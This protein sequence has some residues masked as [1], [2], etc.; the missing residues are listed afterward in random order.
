[1]F[2]ASTTARSAS[3]AAPPRN[4]GTDDGRLLIQCPG[5]P[6]IVSSISTFPTKT[7]ANIV[8]LDQHATAE[9]SGAFFQR[10]ES[11]LPGLSAVREDIEHAFAD[12]V[13]KVFQ[14]RFRSAGGDPTQ[15]CGNPGLQ[16]RSLHAGSALASPS[17]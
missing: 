11:H 16:G 1:M 15:A 17:R 9:Q 2:L 13:A 4:G 14:M 8:A 5:Q 3:R 12:E 6:G 7:G 10:T